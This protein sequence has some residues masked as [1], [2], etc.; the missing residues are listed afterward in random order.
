MSRLVNYVVTYGVNSRHLYESAGVFEKLKE[1]KQ[2]YNNIQLDYNF[3][4][5]RLIRL[6]YPDKWSGANKVDVIHE[7]VY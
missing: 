5:K 3:K 4:A 6:S 2:A 7:V 1:A